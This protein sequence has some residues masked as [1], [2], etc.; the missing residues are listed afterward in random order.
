LAGKKNG[1]LLS[2]AEEAGF[3]V[4]ITLDRGIEYERNLMAVLV[5]ARSSRLVDLLPHVTAILEKV[6][7]IERG[8]LVQ[9]P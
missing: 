7:S 3:Q 2:L 6:G 9:I 8:Q 1:E 4:F 5:R